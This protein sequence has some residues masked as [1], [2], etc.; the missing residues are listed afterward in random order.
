MVRLTRI[1]EGG[2]K[3]TILFEVYEFIMYASTLRFQGR[4]K[5]AIERKK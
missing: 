4:K 1:Y 5:Q 2:F 3:I